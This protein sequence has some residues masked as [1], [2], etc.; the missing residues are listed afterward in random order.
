MTKKIV[1][2]EP[3]V[4]IERL[5]QEYLAAKSFAEKAQE[6]ADALKKILNEA[7]ESQ[8]HP[9]ERGHLWVDAGPYELKRE[10]RVSKN[11]DQ[12]A[13]MEWLDALPALRE[14]CVEYVPQVNEDRLLG[15]AWELPELADPIGA[16]YKERV[17]WAFKVVEK[18]GHE[19]EGEEE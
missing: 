17:T 10:R 15:V 19:S 2:P 1:R 5:T 11:L 16:L 7:V 14:S 8:G 6:R 3:P 4:D 12:R 18:K 13:A 9:D